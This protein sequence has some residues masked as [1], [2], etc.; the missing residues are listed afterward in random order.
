MNSDF[1][2]CSYRVYEHRFN[3]EARTLGEYVLESFGEE[4][5]EKVWLEF[6][7]A[8]FIG[9]AH[10]LGGEALEGEPFRPRHSSEVRS[11]DCGK[12]T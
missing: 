5:G 8:V 4:A 11:C 12:I 1:W 7:L 3:I 6:S 9:G 10:G 2:R